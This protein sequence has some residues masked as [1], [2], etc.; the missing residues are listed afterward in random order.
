MSDQAGPLGAVAVVTDNGPGRL[1]VAVSVGGQSFTGDEPVSAGGTG[2][3]P[4]PHDLLAAG[5]AE[6][7]VLTVRLY[8]DR[9]AWPLEAIEV[10]VS[11][12]LQPQM[13]PRD[14]FRRTLRLTGPLDEAQRQRLMEIAERCP[15]HRTLET[16]SRIET[17]AD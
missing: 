16:G 9:K 13:T 11:H 12:E 1:D 17:L 10:S 7:T 3:G 8:A 15:V 5:L 14:V 4:A 2:L 6:C